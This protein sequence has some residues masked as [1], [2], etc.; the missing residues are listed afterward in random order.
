M[1]PNHAGRVV[2]GVETPQAPARYPW[3]KTYPADVD[4]HAPLSAEPLHVILERTAK[5]HGRRTCTYFFGKSL[6]YAEINRLADSVAAGLQKR[7]VGKG[8][9]VGL[10]L[11]NCPAFIIFYYGILKAGGTVVNFNPLY[12]IE[13]LTHQARDANLHSL[14]TLDLK[15]L[16]PK[17]EALL[18]G[19]A[20]SSLIVCQFAQLLPAVSAILFGLFKK[21][22]I[23]G[24]RQSPYGSRIV[25]YIALIADGGKPQPVPIDPKTDVA[26]IQYTGGTTGIP[27]GAMLTHANL[28]INTRQN[29]LWAHDVVIGEE[30]M[31]GILP[32]FH[33]FGMT[34]IMNAGIAC[35]ATLVLLP[36]FDLKQAL[37]LIRK[38]RPTLMPGVP[39]LYTALMNSPDLRPGDLA[40]LKFCISGGAPLPMEVKRGFEAASGCRLVEGYGLSETSPTATGNPVSGVNKEGSIGIPLPGTRV[41]IRSL[42]DPAKELLLGENGEICIAGPQVMKG[43]WQQPK[44]TADAMAG[45]FLRT[46]DV[47]YMDAEGYTFIVDR[48]KDI[49]LC[50]GFNVYPRNIEEAIYRFP[51]VE[52]VIVVGIPD[53]YRGE[54]PKAFI[55]LKDGVSATKQDILTFLEAKLSKIEM[56]A[57]IEFRDA[58][59]KTLIGKLSKKDLR[60]EIKSDGNKS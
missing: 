4:W 8:V 6:S 44:E 9:N 49:I 58:L 55:K 52:E 24:W 32:L 38:M 7:G 12:T 15:A 14:V 54:A 53:T 22:E 39:T 18:A 45:E 60:A 3:L 2:N 34:T 11:P 27:K 13:E 23:A 33:V 57:E 35:A 25:P 17:A 5:D 51:G 21:S 29:L 59:P 10:L 1:D 28:S 47:G 41:S 46:G 48:I 40:S 42:D 16:F 36:R 43:Y 19:N 31:M 20:V 56:P 50:S 26:V 30:R 37:K